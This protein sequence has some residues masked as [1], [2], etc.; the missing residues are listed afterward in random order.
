MLHAPVKRIVSD[1]KGAVLFVHGIVSTPRFFD[2]FVA[3]VP[4]D[5][6]V[7]SLLLPG[8]GG[9]VTDFGRSSL[10]AWT[11]HVRAA[12]AELRQRHERV[13]IVAHS[14]GTLLSLC[15]VVRDDR[16]IAGLLLLCVPLRIRVKPS[17]L[18][19]NALKGLGLADKGPELASYYGTSQDWR[20]W[21]YLRWI[22]RYL[23]LFAVSAAARKAVKSLSVPGRVFMAGRDELVSLR[24]M[25]E[26][27]HLPAVT[28]AVLPDSMHHDFAPKDKAALLTA[29][30]D[31]CGWGSDAN[32]ECSGDR[33][34]R[35]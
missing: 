33:R 10:K 12:I 7:H 26:M 11:A 20:V 25:R 3:A 1:A 16:C 13:Y 8:H 9:T 2:D 18:L 19:H 32:G 24:S 21:R 22:P 29:M 17:A 27:E 31:M 34:Q 6:S 15:E 28:C 35:K 14:L 5:W 23:E 30:A 4:P